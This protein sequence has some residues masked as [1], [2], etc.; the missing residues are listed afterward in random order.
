MSLTTKESRVCYNRIRYQFRSV[1]SF[2]VATATQHRDA[3]KKNWRDNMPV[4]AMTA[5]TV[6]ELLFSCKGEYICR[7]VTS[8]APV[9]IA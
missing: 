6:C 2:A 7:L 9:P 5:A 4:P 3:F 8:C 1:I